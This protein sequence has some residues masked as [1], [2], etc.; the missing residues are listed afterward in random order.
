V[1]ITGASAGIGLELARIFAGK[2]YGIIAVARNRR[3]LEELSSELEEKYK[4][5]A[6]ILVKDLAE[7]EAAAQIHEELAKKGI[8]V[9][10]LVNNAGFGNFGAFAGQ[11]LEN[12]TSMIQV[13]ITA[14][15]QL[16]RLFL[17][18]M[19]QRHQGHILNIASVAAYSPGPLMAV[20]YATKAYVL[21]FSEALT[22]ELAESG[23]RVTA[24][25]PGPT[26]SEFQRR[27]NMEGP[28][29]R[30]SAPMMSSYDVAEACFNGMLA[31]RAVVIPGMSNKLAAFSTR[32]IPRSLSGKIVRK[33]KEQNDA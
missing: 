30:K 15:T 3:K 8:N 29:H 12:M 27:A 32:F 5:P 31:N 7:P 17:P 23:V 9:D 19:I 13:N 28:A 14:L 21:S 16:T 25:C 20:Y 6:V 10:I 26:A 2:G 33:L 18:D 22:I 1:L 11:K 4:I 24:V